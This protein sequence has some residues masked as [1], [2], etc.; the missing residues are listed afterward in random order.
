VGAA[1]QSAD[2]A[3]RALGTTTFPA[4]VWLDAE[5]RTRKMAFKADSTGGGSGPG[6]SVAF[7]L[8]DFG[9]G[10]TVQAPT[11][12]QVLDLGSFLTGVPR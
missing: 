6:G 12:D 10:A 5:G 11:P 4:D 7:E 1:K 3:A 8:Y 9:V 2:D